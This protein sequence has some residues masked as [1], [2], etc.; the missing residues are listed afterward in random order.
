MRNWQKENIYQD[1]NIINL[2]CKGRITRFSCQFNF[3]PSEYGIHPDIGHDVLTHYAGD[4]PWNSFCYAWD[5]W[6]KDIK[7]LYFGM[8]RFITR[9]LRLSLIPWNV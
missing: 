4:K 7:I 3:K 1:Q 6:W 2:V 9:Y 5:E 8:G